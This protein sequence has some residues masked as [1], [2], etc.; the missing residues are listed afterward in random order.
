M[1]KVNCCNK[2]NFCQQ[3]S[4]QLSRSHK[5][6]S[7]TRA[8]G[9]LDSLTCLL[10]ESFAFRGFDLIQKHICSGINVSQRFQCRLVHGRLGLIRV[11]AD[12]AEQIFPV[13]G[14][15]NDSTGCDNSSEMLLCWHLL[16]FGISVLYCF[17]SDLDESPHDSLLIC[18]FGQTIQNGCVSQGLKSL[19]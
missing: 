19:P 17:R 6:F 16:L 7:V 18:V 1:C 13:R 14:I 9:V 15:R 2:N 11:R 12:T 4:R 5:S 8:A 10:P 3:K